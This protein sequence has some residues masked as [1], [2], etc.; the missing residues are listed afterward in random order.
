MCD[1]GDNTTLFWLQVSTRNIIPPEGI[2]ELH[3]HDGMVDF[4]ALVAENSALRDENSA[5]K[6]DELMHDNE[7]TCMLPGLVEKALQDYQKAV[8]TPCQ[9]LVTCLIVRIRELEQQQQQLHYEN[10]LSLARETEQTLRNEKEELRKR[11]VSVEN[12]YRLQSEA[13]EKKDREEEAKPVAEEQECSEITELKNKTLKSRLEFE[14]S[15]PTK[16]PGLM[17]KLTEGKHTLSEDAAARNSLQADS[18]YNGCKSS[19]TVDLALLP[20]DMQQNNGAVAG[21]LSV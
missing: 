16:G 14:S 18:G 19:Q 12:M 5:L 20:A 4:Q 6:T 9:E 11:L 2:V 3:G 10:E 13:M 8:T 7:C 21:S 1:C 17:S 15:K